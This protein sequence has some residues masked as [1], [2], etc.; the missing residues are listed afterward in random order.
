MIWPIAHRLIERLLLG[1]CV[2]AS[3]A[4]CS[5]SSRAPSEPGSRGGSTFHGVA[6]TKAQIRLSNGSIVI[7]AFDQ[8]VTLSVGPPAKS[9][10]TGQ[11]QNVSITFQS[12]TLSQVPQAFPSA[13]AQGTFSERREL[14]GI[15][16]THHLM[17]VSVRHEGTGD[18]GFLALRD[19]L[20]THLAGV[21]EA[22][23]RRS[24]GGWVRTWARLQSLNVDGTPQAIV[25]VSLSAPQFLNASASATTRS[26]VPLLAALVRACGRATLPALALAQ[27][28][29]CPRQEAETLLTR[30]NWDMQLAQ[31]R[32]WAESHPGLTNPCEGEGIT[33]PACGE[34][35]NIGTNLSIKWGFYTLALDALFYCHNPEY[36]P[37]PREPPPV[38]YCGS[39]AGG[40]PGGGNETTPPWRSSPPPGFKSS[41]IFVDTCSSTGGGIGGGWTCYTEDMCWDAYDAQTFEYLW[42][43]CGPT[44]VC[45]ANAS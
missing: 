11:L 4:G 13:P 34:F 18:H 22:R 43:W 30:W 24:G 36:H 38:R 21:A 33:S 41:P 35:M 9:W 16:G 23:Y 31:A 7:I 25:E 2:A 26:E 28:P 1:A 17:D 44:T 8:A 12:G 42:T 19:S 20:P 37:I 40:G 32:A 10:V 5:D 6:T 14:L 15:G 29:L 27:D 3:M 45:D 39:P